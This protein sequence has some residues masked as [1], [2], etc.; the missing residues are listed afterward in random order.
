M[1]NTSEMESLARALVAP[2]KA[3]LQREQARCNSAAR[4][5]KYEGE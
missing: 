5:G 4:F 1:N 2:G 3:S